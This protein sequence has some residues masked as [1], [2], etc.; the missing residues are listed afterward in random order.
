MY[1]YFM[2]EAKHAFF[3]VYYFRF[4][5]TQQNMKCAISRRNIRLKFYCKWH[6]SSPPY[7]TGKENTPLHA[8]Y[9]LI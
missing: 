1:T 7:P 5:H 3:I 6:S 8:I 2:F 4:K 9:P